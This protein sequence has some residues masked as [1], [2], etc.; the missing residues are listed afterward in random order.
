MR[1]L[2]PWKC[3][4]WII[5]FVCLSLF[6]NDKALINSYPIFCL[7]EEGLRENFNIN[8][9]TNS[10]NVS[11]NPLSLLSISS[12]VVA[13]SWGI[14]TK[15]KCRTIIYKWIYPMHELQPLSMRSYSFYS[16][17]TTTIIYFHFIHQNIISLWPLMMCCNIYTDKNEKENL[18]YSFSL[19]N[20]TCLNDF[21]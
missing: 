4:R 2:R 1:F 14:E 11:W 12:L 13:K 6:I 18:I 15:L 3:S 9:C 10:G 5:T 19:M 17:V 16:S 7:Q 20:R 8:G 21:E